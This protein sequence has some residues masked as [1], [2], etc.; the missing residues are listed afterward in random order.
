MYKGAYPDANTD[1]SLSGQK[2]QTE[3][4]IIVGSPWLCSQTQYIFSPGPRETWFLLPV[5]QLHLID[6]GVDLQLVAVPVA[7]MGLVEVAEDQVIGKWFSE[8]EGC[9]MP[10]GV[11]SLL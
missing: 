8:E 4:T 10:P 11:I 3:H 5:W 7:M 1:R 9:L 6:F 2:A